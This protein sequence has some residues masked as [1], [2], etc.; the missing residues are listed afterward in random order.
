MFDD[1]KAVND[2]DRSIH[3]EVF[4]QS[5]DRRERITR[6]LTGKLGIEDISARDEGL[7]VEAL[8]QLIRE[9]NPLI[10]E[11]QEDV[12]IFL[13]EAEEDSHIPLLGNSSRRANSFYDRSKAK[14][15]I[16]T[17]WK[18]YNP[19]YPSFQQGGG[20]CAN[21]VSQVLY[22]GGMPWA[23]D[24]NPANHKLSNNWYCKPGATNKDNDRR[25]TF[26]WKIAAVFKAHWIK[27]ADAH[28][29]YSYSEAIRTMTELS[30]R[31]FLGDVV[32]FCYSN[33]VPYHTLA[34]TGYNRDP[35]YNVRDIV[36]ASHTIDSNTR[37]LYRT[38]LKY[39]SDYK[40]RVY[41]IKIGQ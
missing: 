37:S 28:S 11:I 26:S 33:G 20:D 13:S 36:L 14:A 18:N 25:I 29:I 19:E 1:L 4:I 22:A 21:F 35:E 2:I 41:N 10:S 16:D 24:K 15:Y 23:D 38:M 17:Y 7:A 30:G 31:T 34:V 12:Y 6:F 39:P 32:Q 40:L 9:D 3:D 27:R 8:E 5:I